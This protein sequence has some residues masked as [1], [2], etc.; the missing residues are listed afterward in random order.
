MLVHLMVGLVGVLLGGPC[1]YLA[2]LVIVDLGRENSPHGYS[3][4]EW[5]GS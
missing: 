4:E 1:A 5:W 3:E 2:C